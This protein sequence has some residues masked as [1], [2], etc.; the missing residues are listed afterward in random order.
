[1]P[2]WSVWTLLLTSRLRDVTVCDQGLVSRTRRNG[3]D[4]H[5]VRHDQL[6]RATQVCYARLPDSHAWNEK[7]HRTP[8]SRMRAQP[9]TR[10]FRRAFR[11][12]CCAEPIG[13]VHDELQP[14][15]ARSSPFEN[16]PPIPGAARANTP[17]QESAPRRVGP[18]RHRC[19][20]K[21]SGHLLCRSD[22]L[23]LR[24]IFGDRMH[25]PPDSRVRC[26]SSVQCVRKQVKVEG[27]LLLGAQAPVGASASR[28]SPLT[29]RSNALVWERRQTARALGAQTVSTTQNQ[30]SGSGI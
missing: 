29:A 13:F 23:R 20:S 27:A 6:S 3:M 4:K 19:I 28:R 18:C 12:L 30:T 5:C 11:R 26:L 7:R 1:M 24:G 21:D 25:D 2:S 15:T 16:L 10:V 8:K 22:W 14:R 9:H 17:A